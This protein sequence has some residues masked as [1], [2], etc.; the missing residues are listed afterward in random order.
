MKSRWPIGYNPRNDR[1]CQ[2]GHDYTT[3]SPYRSVGQRLF[4]RQ[5]VASHGHFRDRTDRDP[6]PIWKQSSIIWR[7]FLLRHYLDCDA[8]IINLILDFIRVSHWA[9]SNVKFLHFAFASIDR[10][11]TARMWRRTCLLGK[12]CA[13]RVQ[14]EEAYRHLDIELTTYAGCH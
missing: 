3:A 4:S 12:Q 14:I 10:I 8:C 6:W 1:R 2:I 13:W 11:G 9:S 7:L 5:K